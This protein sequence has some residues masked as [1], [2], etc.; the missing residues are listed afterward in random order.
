M[1]KLG[2]FDLS[3]RYGKV[4]AL[5]DVTLHVTEGERVFVS[6]PNGAGK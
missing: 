1:P 4:P 5:N 6:G 3:V 2:I